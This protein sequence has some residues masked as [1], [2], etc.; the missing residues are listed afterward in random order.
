VTVT[1]G[2][3]TGCARYYWFKPGG[4]IEQFYGVSQA[5]AKKTSAP[6]VTAVDAGIDQTLYRACLRSLGYTRE[7]QWTDPPPQGWYRGIE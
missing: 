6:I 7:E 3:L 2:G 5:G 4:T 1:L